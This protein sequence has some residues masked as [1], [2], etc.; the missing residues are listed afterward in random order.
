VGT[1]QIV[2]KKKDYNSAS[3][4]L[5]VRTA[6]EAA[7]IK[8]YQQAN[9]TLSSKLTINAPAEVIKGENFLIT[10]VQGINQTAVD[11]ADIS[12]DDKS[13]GKTNS[14]GTLTYSSN[15]TGDH[16]LKAEKQ[17]STSATKK[18]S[19][20]SSLK[21]VDLI[22]PEEAYA[23]SDMK[24]S[25]IVENSGS[26]GDIRLLELK[27]NKTVVDSKNASAEAGKNTT[28]N[29]TYKPANPG[30][31]EF[32]V[33]DVSKTINVETPKSNTWLIALIVV[34]LIAIGAGCYLYSK[35]ELDGLQ[36]QIKRMMQGR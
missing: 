33:D 21:V 30:S 10:V 22:L 5:V 15:V 24:I 20:A 26:K 17:G 6:S 8:A 35:G 28:V 34:L 12:L 23:G 7:S 11:G 2:A 18:I 13:I 1:Y 31:T 36:Q 32:S 25:A 3:A 29:F 19:I 9:A 16:T 4:N 27:A 14:Q